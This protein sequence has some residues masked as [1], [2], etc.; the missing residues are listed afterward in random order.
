MPTN[1]IS[2][3]ASKREAWY[4]LCFF[5]MNPEY[6]R[7]LMLEMRVSKSFVKTRR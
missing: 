2:K 6:G 3:K 1:R 7:I 4:F 5:K